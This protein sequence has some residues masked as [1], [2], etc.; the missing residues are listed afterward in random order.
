[1]RITIQNTKKSLVDDSLRSFIEKK[2]NKLMTFYAEIQNADVFF[3]EE[4]NTNKNKGMEVKLY[5]PGHVLFAK[6]LSHSFEHAVNKIVESLRRQLRKVKTK[7]QA[8]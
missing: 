7:Q 3:F 8:V 6:E 5:I 4:G 2:L 1:M